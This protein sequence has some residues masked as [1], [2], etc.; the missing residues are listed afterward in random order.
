M[1]QNLIGSK[2]IFDEQTSDKHFLAHWKELV[3]A[4]GISYASNYLPTIISKAFELVR[5]GKQ[6]GPKNFSLA[7]KNSLFEMKAKILFGANFE[8]D[9]ETFEYW[10]PGKKKTQIRVKQFYENVL[11]DLAQCNNDLLSNLLK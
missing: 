9:V 10:A 2:T 11:S 3:H 4:I 6:E 8:D 7:I 1:G 5:W